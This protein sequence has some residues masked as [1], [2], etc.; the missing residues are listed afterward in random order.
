MALVMTDIADRAQVREQLNLNH[1]LTRQ[2]ERA[3]AREQP[4]EIE[5]KRVCLDCFE[6]LGK[7]RLK[8]NPDAVRC[9]ECQEL[10]EQLERRKR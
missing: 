3:A 10:K 6:P 2:A 8:A 1:A 9:V 7:K 5:G 4:F